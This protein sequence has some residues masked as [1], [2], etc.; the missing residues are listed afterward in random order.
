VFAVAAHEPVRPVSKVHQQR[1]R[2]MSE[3]YSIQFIACGNTM[4]T[5]GWTDSDMQ[6]F[7]KVD[8]VGAAAVLELQE[9]GYAYIAW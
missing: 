1:I 2:C 3:S 5:I 6:D 7:V 4:H 9:K 8:D